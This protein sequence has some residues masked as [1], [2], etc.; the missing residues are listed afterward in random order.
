MIYCWFSLAASI[1][2]LFTANALSANS[3]LRI[4][5]PFDVKRAKEFYLSDGVDFRQSN[6][7]ATNINFCFEKALSLAGFGYWCSIQG[8]AYGNEYGYGFGLY[9]YAYNYETKTLHPT[10]VCQAIEEQEWKEVPEYCYYGVCPLPRTFDAC[11]YRSG[12]IRSIQKRS[13]NHGSMF[14]LASPMYLPVP[15]ILG[16]TKIFTAE[17]LVM[18]IIFA[19]EKV[20]VEEGQIECFI[21]EIITLAHINHQNVI[22]FL[23]CC[24][25]TE[26]PILVYEFTS[27]GTLFDYIHD[28]KNGKVSMPHWDILMEIASESAAGLAY[29]HSS[30]IIHGNVKSSNILLTDC[31]AKVAGFGPPSL[32][33][34][35]ESQ[36]ST[37]VQR[38]LGYLDPEY[39]VT[40]QLTDKS[41]VY[42]FGVVLVEILTGEKPISFNRPENQRIITCLFLLS[43]DQQNSLFQILAPQVKEEN[44]E[45]VRA[46]AELAKQCLKLSS[47]E[48]P[49]ME[50]VAGE[51]K[52]LSLLSDTYLTVHV[53]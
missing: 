14:S 37:L 44:K 6:N 48:R 2:F 1:L 5:F 50:E 41:D 19:Q 21:N 43:M 7:N 31:L 40:G 12:I 33:P 16:C 20:L 11:S 9:A 29:L 13:G 34:S 25:E 26:A 18:E 36:I 15:F 39:F 4:P 27:N 47:A 22:K 46:V 52:R 30:S 10:D 42:S 24:L 32:V 17:E 28:W 38:T 53:S 23:G 45:Q 35:N 3:S 49:T 51:L 8:D